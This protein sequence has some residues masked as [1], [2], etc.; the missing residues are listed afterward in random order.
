MA[1]AATDRQD[2]ETIHGNDANDT[3]I[4]RHFGSSNVLQR[5]LQSANCANWTSRNEQEHV[6]QANAGN[7]LEANADGGSRKISH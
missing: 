5:I 1:A 7:D 3:A 4:T 6:V 2:L